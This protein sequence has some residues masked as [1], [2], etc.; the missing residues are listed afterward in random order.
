[1]LPLYQQGQEGDETNP[2]KLEIAPSG[3][4]L[5]RVEKDLQ[6][7]R[8]EIQISGDYRLEFSTAKKSLASVI[9]CVHLDQVV[10]V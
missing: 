6:G 1:M 7:F 10:E 4:H 9:W 8:S 2:T 5:F 3:P